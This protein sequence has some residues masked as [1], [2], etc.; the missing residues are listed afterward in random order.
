MK[1]KI[2]EKVICIPP[3]ISSTWD[4]VSFLQT[5][6]EVE[7]TLALMI[8][9]TDGKVVRI[10]HL[11]SSIIDITFG[12]HL[13]YLEGAAVVEQKEA[14]GPM[15]LIQ[16]LLGLSPEQVSALPIR[17]G[18]AKLPI[19]NMEAAFQHN[20]AQSGA[21]NL[22]KEAV[23]STVQFIKVL[24]NGDLAS[25]PKP[26]PHCN[27]THCQLARHIHGK[28]EPAPEEPVSDEELSFRTWDIREIHKNL[29]AVSNPLDPREEY[30]VYLGKPIGCTCGK[31]HCEHIR[32][33]LQS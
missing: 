2:T 1:A 6:E 16:H 12:A 21:A 14:A 9:L 23:E 20:P 19:E 33:V 13:R 7:G 31:P 4:Q 5:E 15:G 3:Y 24:S 8:H 29:F 10:P 25:F 32:S 22:S 30:N 17:L 26:E 28:E 18:I 27:C 11:D